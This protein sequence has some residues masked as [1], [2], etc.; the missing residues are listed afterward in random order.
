MVVLYFVINLLCLSYLGAL[1]FDPTIPSS[2]SVIPW[3]IGAG[4]TSLIALCIELRRP[5]LPV[6]GVGD[7]I[8]AVYVP[9]AVAVAPE[10]EILVGRVLVWEA[11]WK[12]DKGRNGGDWAM[13]PRS[14]DKLEVWVPLKDLIVK[15]RRRYVG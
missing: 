15:E 11:V 9:K 10:A 12:I 2:P 3:C 7:C 13:V 14:H 1:V 4:A 8:S 5:P 6:Q